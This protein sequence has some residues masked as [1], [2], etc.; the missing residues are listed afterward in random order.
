MKKAVRY[1]LTAVSIFIWLM[2]LWCAV[3]TALLGGLPETI[4]GI[5]LI[6]FLFAALI[7][8]EYKNNSMEE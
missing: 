6:V 1:L 5:A 7:I 4:S 3:F 2:L 8:Y